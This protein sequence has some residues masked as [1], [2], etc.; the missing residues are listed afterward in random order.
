MVTGSVPFKGDTALSVA[1]KH[2]SKI[3]P[4]PKKLNPEVSENL[5][6]LIL[7]CMEKDRERRYQTAGEL[8]SELN[9]IEKGIP[10]AERILLKRRLDIKWKSILLY[11]GVPLLLILFI[12]GAITMFTGRP[13]AIDSIA[14]LPFE[15]LSG[16]PNQEYLSDGITDALIH[17]LSKISALRVISRTSVMFYKKEPKPLPEIASELNVGAVVEASVLTDG[18]MVQIKAKLIRVPSEENLWVQSFDRQMSD[19]LALQGEMAQTIAQKIKIK[20]TTE[21]KSLLTSAS[22]VNPEAHKAFLRGRHIFETES[23]L[24]GMKKAIEYFQN[25]LAIN[26]NYALAYVGL[27]EAWFDLAFNF[28]PPAQEEEMKAAKRKARETAQRALEIDNTLSEAHSMMAYFYFYY[29]WNWLEAESTFKRALELNP[30]DSM[31]RVK[32]VEFLWAMGRHDEAIKQAKRAEELDPLSTWMGTYVG[33]TLHF[34]RQTDEAIHKLK[35]VLEREP[36][37]TWARV[38]LGHCYWDKGLYKEAMTTWAKMHEL[39][40]NKELAKAFVE[41]GVDEAVHK[42]LEQA[43][44]QVASPVFNSRIS[45]AVVHAMLGEKEQ[46]LEWLE[47]AYFAREPNVVFLKTKYNW[48]SLRDD[49]RFQ[50]LVRRMNFP[51]DK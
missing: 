20:L 10:I 24:E 18:S 29:D 12:V 49:P 37:S 33:I 4:D 27:S 17:E 5:S 34:A 31:S 23:T 45:I 46:A 8:L 2:K 25:A 13:G 1:L 14:V 51:E 15:N 30:N 42:W 50:D 41:L 3:P 38:K 28:L 7:I 48:D 26:P 44:G 22:S 35:E 43:K 21:E 9:K 11:G 6:R 16:D 19:I 32:Y 40:G 36:N 47:K 39:T